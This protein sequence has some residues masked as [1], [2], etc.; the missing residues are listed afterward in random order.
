M[1]SAVPRITSRPAC[2]LSRVV[3]VLMIDGSGSCSRVTKLWQRTVIYKS[4]AKSFFD[5][6]V[7]IRASDFVINQTLEISWIE[8][9]EHRYL[10]EVQDVHS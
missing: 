8:I 3:S 1:S 4:T 6:S 10:L 5:P 9:E 2:L 7:P